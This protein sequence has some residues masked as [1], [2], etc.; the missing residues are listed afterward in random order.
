MT[1]TVTPAE[2]SAGAGALVGL[3]AS[4]FVFK[5]PTM[6]EIAVG[7]LIGAGVGYLAAQVWASATAASSAGAST[8]T[9]TG[10]VTSSTGTTTDTS[11]S[12]SSDAGGGSSSFSDAGGGSSS[13]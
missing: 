11:G 13:F 1:I 3:V 9:G 2:E 4:L 8:D 12:G 10:T 6:T 5:K 7:G